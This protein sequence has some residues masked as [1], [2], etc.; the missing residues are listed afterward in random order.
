MVKV[1]DTLSIYGPNRSVARI[2]LLPS[3]PELFA[4]LNYFVHFLALLKAISQG[5]LR[6]N[7]V[8]FLFWIEITAIFRL[9][10][11]WARRQLIVRGLLMGHV[12]L[13][14][15]WG[16]QIHTFLGPLLLR[17]HHFG[18]VS[19][20][21]VR[22]HRLVIVSPIQIEHHLLLLLLGYHGVAI[23]LIMTATASTWVPTKGSWTTGASSAH[24]NRVR[25]LW[26]VRTKF[27][28]VH[29]WFVYYVHLIFF[30]RISAH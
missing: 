11:W 30:D 23:A 2:L 12:L 27:V 10:C 14:R 17:E 3:F 19:R 15:A 26:D 4:P 24:S 20:S 25:M 8:Q 5:P 13:V 9:S 22:L 7:F 29:W 18:V 21:S 16:R 28:V 1:L 6:A